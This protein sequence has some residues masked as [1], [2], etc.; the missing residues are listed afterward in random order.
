MIIKIKIKEDICEVFV[1]MAKMYRIRLVK[2][3]F[4]ATDTFEE[5]VN[6]L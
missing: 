3:E 2:Y 1:F 6:C 4:V 5:V